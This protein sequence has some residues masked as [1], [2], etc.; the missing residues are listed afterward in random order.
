[1]VSA[2]AMGARAIAS[3]IAAAANPG[4]MYFSLIRMVVLLRGKLIWTRCDSILLGSIAVFA[5][6]N[7]GLLLG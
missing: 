7:S 2:L 5:R 6:I 1:L 4:A 3:P